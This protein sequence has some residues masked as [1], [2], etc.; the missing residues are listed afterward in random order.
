M[1]KRISGVFA[2]LVALVVGRASAAELTA[3]QRAE[4]EA[5]EVAALAKARTAADS[6]RI[7]YNIIDLRVDSKQRRQPS[8]ELYRIAFR[9]RREGDAL[10]AMR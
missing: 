6:I 2:V 3:E 9:T 7:L 10:C 1:I 4:A 8:E 5:A